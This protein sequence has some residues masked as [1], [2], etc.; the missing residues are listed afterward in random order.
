[1]RQSMNRVVAAAPRGLKRAV[2]RLP[3]GMKL[4]ERLYDFP[5]G[6]STASGSR[7]PVVY[8]PTW[9]GWETMKQ[10]PQY[11][12]EALAAAG[13]EVWFV[14][15]RL[16]EATEVNGRI[17]L[18]PSVRYTPRSGVIVY[19]HFAPTRSLIDRY[20]DRVVVYDLLDDLTI[21]EP[22]EH[23]MPRE[24]RVRHHHE[25]LVKSADVVIA[26]NPILLERHRAE[27]PDILLVE[28]G[29]DLERFDSVGPI[30]D[31]LPEGQVV[32]YHGAL[33]P[34]F[35]FE[36]LSAVAG[37]RP[38]LDFVLVGPV[39][40]E[41]RDE[42]KKLRQRENITLI[43]SQSSEQI[44]DFV[45]GFEVGVLP[46]IIDQMTE[47]VTPLKMYEYLA[48]GVPMVGTPLPACVREQAVDTASGPEDFAA[49]ID[50]ALARTPGERL[51]LRR[52]A[53]TADWGSRVAPLIDLLDERGQLFVG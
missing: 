7:R 34:W 30:A 24:R 11:V 37:L 33:A 17:H 5:R 19:T 3:G 53:L 14:D 40:P 22:S 44:A 29:V 43:P 28:N 52:H 25:P 51:D 13:H 18:V 31:A 4:R 23:D 39:D 15:S 6:P 20:T 35:D 45:R 8:L 27:R 41:V 16:E 49:A 12:L 32:G 48:C 2:K 50:A 46:F 36:L 26:S 1:M 21:Y 47:A 38:D 10:R 9:L 42:A